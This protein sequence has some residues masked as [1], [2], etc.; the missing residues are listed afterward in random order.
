MK[1]TKLQRGR[2]LPSLKRFSLMASPTLLH[3]QTPHGKSPLTKNLPNR[4]ENQKI[5]SMKSKKRSY[6]AN[7][8]AVFSW[9]SREEV[10]LHKRRGAR[11]LRP[12]YVYAHVCYNGNIRTLNTL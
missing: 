9:N 6:A 10:C 4:R 8:W 2:S 11:P 12:I 1:A 7:C 3:L 5:Q